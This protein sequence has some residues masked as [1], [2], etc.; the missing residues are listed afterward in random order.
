[1]STDSNLLGLYT[2]QQTIAFTDMP[3]LRPRDAEKW[4]SNLPT[5]HVGETARLI[6][7]AIAEI[8]RVPL[9]A[10]QRFKILKLFREPFEYVSQ[11]LQKKYINLAFP[12]SAK[13]LTIAELARELQLE[14]AI[15]YKI[16]IE[17]SISKK[18]GRVSSKLLLTAIFRAMHYL[19]ESL[20]NS[21]LTYSPQPGQT[22]LEIHHLYLFSEH[23]NL[24]SKK[25]SDDI[26]ASQNNR[27]IG[28]L[29]KHIILLSLSNPY[30]LPQVEILRVNNALI[31]WAK[32]SSLHIFD[33]TNKPGGLFAIDMENNAAPSYYK[34]SQKT[35]NPEYIRIFDT[36]ELIRI[37]RNQYEVSPPEIRNSI[38]HSRENPDEI[39]KEILHRL[40]MAWGSA[41]KRSFSRKEKP[42]EER[43]NITVG[44][45]ATHTHIQAQ[46]EAV[47]Q[48]ENAKI[49]DFPDS[50]VEFSE[51]A[52]YESSTLA[53]VCEP[54]A[55][56]D[57][58][59][60]ALNPVLEYADEYSLTPFNNDQDNLKFTSNPVT[61]TAHQENQEIFNCLLIN[62]SARGYCAS[63]DNNST[64]KTIVG[65]LI[66]IRSKDD[67]DWGIGVIRWLQ[68][69][70]KTPM[71]IGIQ[72]LSPAAH[73]I[74]S[75]NLSHKGDNGEYTRA[76]LIP[77]LQSIKQPQTLITQFLYNA[78]DELEL[79]VHGQLISVRLTKELE[80][81]NAF[82]QFEFVILKPKKK[83]KSIDDPDKIKNFDSVWSSI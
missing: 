70:N 34:T 21:C 79:D 73:A 50:Q 82:N 77:E 66:G 46:H 53:G 18:S 35:I 56:P 62:E 2:P 3:Y 54:G 52:E 71:Y 67:E 27:S 74:A 31:D 29:Y 4:I 30:R 5:A 7:K 49:S 69:P 41:P 44:L 15:G 76:L 9:P 1:M 28:S 72:L 16:I 75:R 58:W 83:S 22:W 37:L 64:T 80:S 55:H 14:F 48:E 63:W 57:V 65:S 59:D 43:I 42:K 38:L 20:L 39:S 24:V 11:A 33:N 23:N 13:N 32:Y 60:M 8:N 45:A 36:D 26:I 40:I 6:Y 47:Q 12:L 68:S 19:G 10:Q 51:K 78:G 17:A 81:S 25:V 61:L